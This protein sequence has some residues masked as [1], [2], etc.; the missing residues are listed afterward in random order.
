MLQP[1]MNSEAIMA[2]TSFGMMI[3]GGV[4]SLVSKVFVMEKLS[5]QV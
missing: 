3:G 5:K 4:A 2:M 1:Q